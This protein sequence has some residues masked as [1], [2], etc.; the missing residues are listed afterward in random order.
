M[1][2]LSFGPA[3]LTF[4]KTMRLLRAFRLL[5]LIGLFSGTPHLS[6]RTQAP[7]CLKCTRCAQPCA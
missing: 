5:R 1:T 7:L 3:N 6:A 4:F 2:L